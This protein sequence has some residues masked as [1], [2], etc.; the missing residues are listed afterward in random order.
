[1]V[2]KKVIEPLEMVRNIVEQ[3]DREIKASNQALKL[4]ESYEETEISK[5]MLYADYKDF[6][7]TLETLREYV[8]YQA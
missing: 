2:K 5:E 4:I 8:I 6:V 7:R 1:M 3:F